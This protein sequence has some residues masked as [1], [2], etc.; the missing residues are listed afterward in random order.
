VQ[1]QLRSP[2]RYFINPVEYDTQLVDL[3]VIPGGDPQKWR[4]TREGKLDDVGTQPMVGLIALQAGQYP[5][6]GRGGRR[7]GYK[8][9]QK[10]VLTPGTYKINPHL[11]SVTLVPAVVVPPGFVGVTTRLTGDRG[12][13]RRSR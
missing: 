9:I 11:Y 2:G 6:A 1:E 4:F 7:S 8:G 13:A 3:T 5:P 10:E 12:R